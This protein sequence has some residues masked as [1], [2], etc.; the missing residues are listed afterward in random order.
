MRRLALAAAASCALLA[1]PTAGKA[2][3]GLDHLV[4]VPNK[5]SAD[6]AVIDTRTDRVVRRI[7]VGALPHQVAVSA[8]LG[9]LVSTNS[10][11]GTI[12]VVDLAGEAPAGRIALDRAPEHMELAPS[13]KLLA[14]ANIEAGSVSLV[15]LAARRET[16]RIEGFHAPHN[17][18]FADGGRLLYVANLAADAVS[19]VDVAAARVVKE[20][21]LAQPREVASAA[22]GA[23]FQ[24]VVNV[25][26]SADGR[27]GFAAFGSGNGLAVIDL[28]GQEVVKRL[29]LGEVPWRAYATADGRRMVV[30]NNGDATV[31]IV[32]T[33]TLEE[34][35]RLEGAPS[36]TGVNTGWFG[37]T[38]FVL[39]REARAALVVDL[40]RGERAGEIA[41]PG[42]P[43]TGVTTPDGA[44]LY[45]ALSDV[46]AVAVID[47]RERR[48]V[49]VV[50]NVGDGP[51]GAHMT[52]AANYCH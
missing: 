33:E 45:V 28:A 20:I 3:A 34:V 31:S 52:G 48:L 49:R 19:V 27:L 15:D 26:P 22:A 9:L 23:D 44:K 36:M 42:M 51:W 1:M 25:T 4:F 21:G 39:S 29:T 43:E 5:D 35:A 41:L 38:A 37:T 30:P 17:L 11:E 24:G 50:E 46:G 2:A 10:G 13:G 47:T 8:S 14:V 7:A 6:V 32:D 12:S 40:E 16:A 18:T